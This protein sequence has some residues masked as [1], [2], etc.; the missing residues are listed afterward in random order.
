MPHAQPRARGAPRRGEG[1]ANV[2]VPGRFQVL[3]GPVPLIL[4]VAHNPQAAQSLAATLAS[5]PIPG[6]TYAVTAVM[7]DK[8]IGAIFAAM[9]PVIDHWS[10]T[11]V[12]LARAAKAAQLAE[13]LK[14]TVAEAKYELSD[15]VT[16]ALYRLARQVKPNDRV[17][18]FGSF[19]TVA[20]VMTSDYNAGLVLSEQQEAN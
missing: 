10:L 12:N 7:A 8:E 15:S 19:Y 20:E 11:S 2:K 4:D 3:P 16:D 9:A 5:W 13:V 6:K 18:V 1:L 14:S 17:V